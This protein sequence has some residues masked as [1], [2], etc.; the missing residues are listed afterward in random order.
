[1]LVPVQDQHKKILPDIRAE[2][3]LD[4]QAL[5]R[6]KELEDRHLGIAGTA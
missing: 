2:N 3:D 6:Q 5:A 1:M 4:P